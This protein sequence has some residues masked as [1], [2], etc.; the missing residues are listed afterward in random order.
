VVVKGAVLIAWAVLGAV[1]CAARAPGVVPAT[2]LPGS[3]GA[4]HDLRRT[5]AGSHATVLT[6]FSAHCPCQRAHDARL[7][8]LYARYAPRGVAFVAIDS[9]ASSSLALD[10]AEASA[11]RLPFPI[12]SD[13]GG[14]MADALGADYAT[15][16]VVVD[17]AGRVVY[18]GG[19]DS[20]K[21]ELHDDATPFLARALDQ[22]LAGRSPDPAEAKALGC[23]LRRR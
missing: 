8:E 14:N 7:A 11:R 9:E 18:R 2:T 12:V 10:T 22:W 3:D 6:F 23:A 13:P 19:I 15:Y 5:A 17:A 16:S 1:G 20:D 4:S 21:N